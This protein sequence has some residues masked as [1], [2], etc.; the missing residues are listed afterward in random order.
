M[1]EKK[2]I[3]N[4]V[5][6]YKREEKNTC[7]YY[8]L[9]RILDLKEVLREEA[10]AKKLIRYL[11]NIILMFKINTVKILCTFHCK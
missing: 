5:R 9:V 2:T 6:K 7:T 4:L 1:H 10:F 11:K 3:F 8:V